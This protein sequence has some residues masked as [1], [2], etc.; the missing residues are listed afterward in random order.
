MAPAG[1]S[2][3]AT[4]PGDKKRLGGMTEGGLKNAQA[5]LS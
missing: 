1:F 2:E 3:S 4:L 5:P